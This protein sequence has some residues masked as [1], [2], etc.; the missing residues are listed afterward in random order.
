MK[1]FL[2][3]WTSG[4]VIDILMFFGVCAIIVII[5]ILFPGKKSTVEPQT[6]LTEDEW[7]DKFYNEEN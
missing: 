3:F 4:I 2:E 5:H 6:Q 7:F 1:T